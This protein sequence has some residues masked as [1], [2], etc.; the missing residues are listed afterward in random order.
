M[1]V[2][3]ATFSEPALGAETYHTLKKGRA[4]AR[5]STAIATRAASRR[6][7]SP[8]R[9]RCNCCWRR[10]SAR[11]A[12]RA[13][14]SPSRSTPP[15]PSPFRD[16]RYELAGEGRSLSPVEFADSLVDLFTKYP[17]V[18][19]EDAWPKR[20]GTACADLTAN[21]VPRAAR[22]H[23]LF[24]TTPLVWPTASTAAGQLHPVHVN[25]IGSLTE[26]LEAVELAA[27]NS[28]TAVMSHRSGRPRT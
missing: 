23:D 16:G 9:P 22:R 12:P 27:A 19:I 17:I 14:T 25:Q 2:G 18:S 3:A 24:V 21:Q 10:S 20:T 26:T 6:T 1:P 8:T 15:R 11:V 13:T 5:L 28:N 4:R 7:S